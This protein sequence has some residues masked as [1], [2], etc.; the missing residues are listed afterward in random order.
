MYFRGW[1]AGVK[2]YR[3]WSVIGCLEDKECYVDIEVWSVKRVWG[4]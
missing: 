1:R 4:V 2:E 3:V